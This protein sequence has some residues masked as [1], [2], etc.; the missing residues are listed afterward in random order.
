MI[1]N[2]FENKKIQIH[3]FRPTMRTQQK[4]KTAYHRMLYEGEYNEIVSKAQQKG[5]RRITRDARTDWVEYSSVYF[6][7]SK[8]SPTGGKK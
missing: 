5:R 8:L 3:W 1:E 2:D 7:F 6:G 4:E